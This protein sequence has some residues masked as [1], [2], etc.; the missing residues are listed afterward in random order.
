MA[1]PLPGFRG[2]LFRCNTT[3]TRYGA[4][5]KPTGQQITSPK[6]LERLA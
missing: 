6:R 2:A 4:D 5:L 1:F 3:V